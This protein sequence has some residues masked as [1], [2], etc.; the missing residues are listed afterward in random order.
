MAGF[1]GAFYGQNRDG[2]LFLHQYD[3]QLKGWPVEARRIGNT[4]ADCLVQADTDGIQG[5][6][7]LL[8]LLRRRARPRPGDVGPVPQRLPGDAEGHP[9]GP[10]R[11]GA[12]AGDYPAPAIK[13]PSPTE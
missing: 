3:P 8:D 10:A 5:L 11:L 1:N 2:D 7:R 9:P 13:E 4:F 6:Q 12:D